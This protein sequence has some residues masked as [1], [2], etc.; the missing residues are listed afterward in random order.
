MRSALGLTLCPGLV[1]PQDTITLPQARPAIKAAETHG[2]WPQ[3]R[4]EKPHGPSQPCQGK[5]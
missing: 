3:S 4:P 2:F 5:F 1:T